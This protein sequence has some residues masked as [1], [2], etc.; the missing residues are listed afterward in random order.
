MT[1]KSIFT[2]RTVIMTLSL[3]CSC[4]AARAAERPNVVFILSDDQGYA[5]V[6]FHEG[7]AQTPHLDKLKSQ[8]IE[9]RRHYTQP[10]CT[11]TRAALMSG[12]YPYRTAMHAGVV[13]PNSDW[14]LPG[15]TYTM[16]EMFRDAGYQTALIGKWHLGHRRES[17]M[18]E[19]QGFDYFYGLYLGEVH[20]YFTHDYYGAHAL[21]SQRRPV[22][23]KGYMTDLFTEEAVK[24]IEGKPADKP[25]FLYLSYNAPHDPLQAKPE[26]E[27][28]YPK[29]IYKHRKTYL[30]MIDNM[31]Q[32]IGRVLKALEERGILDNTLI[33]FTSDNGGV[34]AREQFA[35]NTPLRAGKGSSYEGAIRTPTLA[36]WPGRIKPGTVSDELVYVADWYRT[37]MKLAGGKLPDDAPALDSFDLL[38]ILKGKGG[39]R[40][41]VAIISHRAHA[42]VTDEWISVQMGP[43][44]VDPDGLKKLAEAP[45]QFGGELYNI[46]DEIWQ[47]TD[48]AKKEPKRFA[49]MMEQMKLHFAATQPS[50]FDMGQLKGPY[51][52]DWGKAVTNDLKRGR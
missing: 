13:L 12:R 27:A 39:K 9:L 30:A 50:K 16:A 42:L 5:D 34:F 45:A 25:L 51:P 48:Q 14:G 52:A 15:E 31:D 36:V 32:G 18:P 21:H 8:G 24:V 26:D 33:V 40:K 35:H 11:P 37:F 1:T 6:G 44:T 17:L 28:K 22:H 43:D 3:V 4:L 38:P 47:R 46:K 19:H 23:T 20:S 7:I 2:I 10:Q 29:V 41:E 49:Q